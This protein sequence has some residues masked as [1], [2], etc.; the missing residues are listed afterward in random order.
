VC[1]VTALHGRYIA[2]AEGL[3][4]AAYEAGKQDGPP[5]VFLHGFGYSHAVFE[6]QFRSE[7]ANYF[8]LIAMDLRGHGYSAKPWMQSS[9]LGSEIWADDLELILATLGVAD[10]TLV[11][12]SYGAMVCMDWFRK[13]GSSRAKNF[14]FTGSHGGLAANSIQQRTKKDQFNSELRK[15]TPDF[16]KDKS[17]SDAFIERMIHRSISEDMH[18]TLVLSRQQLPHYALQA[19]GSRAF[20]NH[21]LKDAINR[22][23]LFIQGEHDFANSPDVIRAIAATVPLSKVE[24]IQGVGHVPSVEAPDQFNALVAAFASGKSA[25]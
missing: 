5:V 8:R 24:I 6:P 19:M 17:E 15:Q 25:K 20:E 22:P 16:S 11:G 7:L 3:P 10:A 9:Y 1:E 21:D 13:Y 12:W 2:T 4:L 18:K 23:L 14:I